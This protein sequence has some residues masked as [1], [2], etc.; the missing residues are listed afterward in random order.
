MLMHRCEENKF[1]L[2]HSS[3]FEHK[4]H[5]SCDEEGQV[6]MNHAFMYLNTSKEITELLRLSTCFP[7][8]EVLENSSGHLKRVLCLVELA[9]QDRLY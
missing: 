8:E 5:T 4:F 1:I 3:V 9:R 6:F 7:F 2:F